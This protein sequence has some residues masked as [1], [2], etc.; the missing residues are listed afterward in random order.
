LYAERD[1][2]LLQRSNKLRAERASDKRR[3]QQRW[4]RRPRGERLENR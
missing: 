2:A 1:G 4:V 3:L